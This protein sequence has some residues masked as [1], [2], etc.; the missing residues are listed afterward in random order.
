MK[1]ELAR[2]RVSL[3]ADL[4]T[5]PFDMPGLTKTPSPGRRANVPKRLDL[6]PRE[7]ARIA[8]RSRENAR[9]APSNLNLGVGCRA[10]SACSMEKKA[11]CRAPPYRWGR[12]RHGIKYGAP[13]NYVR[14]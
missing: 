12:W 1:R 10:A 5:D 14:G 13:P 4:R 7:A 11:V 8:G 3:T 9:R 6:S 2:T